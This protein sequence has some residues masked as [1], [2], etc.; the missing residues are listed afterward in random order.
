MFKEA[1]RGLKWTDSTAGNTRT[2]NGNEAEWTL[3]GS[4][5]EFF[6]QAECGED[7][8]KSSGDTGVEWRGTA[9]VE[10]LK[11]LF[12]RCFSVL[13]FYPPNTYPDFQ[14]S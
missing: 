12:T 7:A 13:P 3:E 2:S 9:A 8:E 10:R 4:G 5:G 1:C 6:E 14:N 11:F